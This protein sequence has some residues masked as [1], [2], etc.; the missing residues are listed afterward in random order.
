VTEYARQREQA[1]EDR[2]TE[3]LGVLVHELRNLLSTVSL[4]CASVL[5]GRVPIGG[6][7]SQ[8]LG[9]NL[10]KLD[11]LITRS[12]TDVRL[13]AGLVRPEPISVAGFVEE[14]EIGA[15]V[16]ARARGIGLTVPAVPEGATMEGDRESLMAA[17]A[18]MLQNAFKFTRKG[19]DVSLTTRVTT[20][21]ICF[22]IADECGGL[23]PGK[24]EELF[25]PFSQRS[26]DRSGVGLGLAICLKAAKASGGEIRVR[27]VP[28]KGCVFTLDL[29]R[30]SPP[31]P[32][33]IGGGQ[34]KGADASPR[35]GGGASEAGPVKARAI[36]SHLGELGVRAGRER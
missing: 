1:V 31:T 27:D 2:G 24:V 8:L 16:E 6:S 18:N 3:R 12:L 19:G 33:A 5:S 22:D 7:T 20:E 17:I 10:V 13:D 35:G 30:A 14:I 29:P 21:R 28:G 9:R 32:L 26:T 23:P 4:A 34:E 11:G 15:S 25:T 36:G